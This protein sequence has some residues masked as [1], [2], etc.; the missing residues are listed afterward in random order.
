[1]L[2]PVT[3][4]PCLLALLQVARPCFTAPTFRTFA[5]LVTGL[6]VRTR[7]R[8]VVGMLL[9]AGLTRM[10]PHDRAHYFFARARW[11]ADQLGLALAHVIVER[12]LPEGTPLQIAVDDTLFHRRGKKIYG[13]AWQYDGSG[14][15]GGHSGFGNNWVVLG[16]LVPLPFLA[17]PICLPVLA[18]LWRP[19]CQRSK[20]ELARELV[21]VLLAAFPH[22]RVDLVGDAAY[23][24]KALRDLPDRCTWT[25]RMRRNGVFYAPAPPPT[26][27]RGHP[28]WKGER[29]G[30]PGEIAATAAFTPHTV[31][32]YGRTQTVLI[33]AVTGL[34]Y[35]AFHRRPCRLLLIREAD[36]TQAYDLAL[37]TTDTAIPPERIVAR[38][39]WRWGIEVLFAQLKHVL[40]V[41]E[42]RNR[43]QRAVERT[44][45]FGLAVYTLTVIWYALH[46]RHQA[47]VEER[48]AQ[49]PWFTTKTTV[50]FEDMHAALRRQVISHRIDDAIPAQAAIVQIRQAVRHLLDLAA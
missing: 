9:G 48:R 23:H 12:L 40:G 34:W 11:S 28:A 27:R 22:R 4:P 10:W 8:T 18:R 39:S 19:G 6:I 37:V 13:A 3:V 45:P 24:G 49:A 7:R 47:D 43:V 42:A 15:G 2:P 46:G 31:E 26:G 17:R 38:Y 1:M 16:L 36:S 33:A 29:L 14:T 32:R 5:A 44:V 25:C 20:V 50:A 21:G 30:T 41:G 35:G